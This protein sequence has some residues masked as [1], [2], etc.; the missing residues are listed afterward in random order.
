LFQSLQAFQVCEFFAGDGH[1]GKT[2]KYGMVA[3]AQLDVEY[4]KRTTRV[5]KQ[6]AFDMLE[7]SGLACLTMHQSWIKLFL[8]FSKRILN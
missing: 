2:A 6:N 5:H 8:C 3:C 4:G 1:V 7:P